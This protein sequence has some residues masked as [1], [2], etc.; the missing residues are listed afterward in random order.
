MMSR[1]KLGMFFFFPLASDFSSSASCN[2]TK[3]L[4]CLRAVDS[5]T[6]VNININTILGGFFGTFSFVP[7]IDGSFITQSPTTALS[8]GKVNGVRISLLAR[9]IF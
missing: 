6:L 7:V 3:A 5:A 4:D 1:A 2:G 8:Q 9:N